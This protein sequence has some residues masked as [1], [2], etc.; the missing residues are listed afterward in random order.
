[1][2]TSNDTNNF[3]ATAQIVAAIS[4]G[5]FLGTTASAALLLPVMGV[6]I[7]T[8]YLAYIT[9]V[10]IAVGVAVMEIALPSVFSIVNSTSEAVVASWNYVSDWWYQT[11]E[12]ETIKAQ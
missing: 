6:A 8:T 5:A 10:G 9:V 12:E 4:L 3:Q 1:M 11:P 7:N 2:T